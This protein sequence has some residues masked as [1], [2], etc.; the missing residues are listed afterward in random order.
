MY[1]ISKAMPH[2]E[3]KCTNSE[4]LER[5]PFAKQPTKTLAVAHYFAPYIVTFISAL[6]DETSGGPPPPPLR[7]QLLQQGMRSEVLHLTDM[8]PAAVIS[9]FTNDH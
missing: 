2:D 5:H 9:L 4:V 3:L 8:C 1:F 7:I 6:C